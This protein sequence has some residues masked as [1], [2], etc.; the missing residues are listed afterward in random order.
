MKPKQLIIAA[1]S[2]SCA[3]PIFA[4][5]WPAYRG[6]THDGKSTE[7]MPAWPARGPHA[8]WKVPTPNGFSSFSVAD[9]RAFTMILREVDG[10]KMEVLVALNA[11]T[12]KE[13][14]SAHFAPA[15]YEGGGDSGTKENSGGDGPRSTPAIDG[16]HVYVITSDLLIACF[17]S[18]SGK[19]I[20]K[21]DLIRENHGK[22]I[23]W[24]NAASPLIEGNILL[25]AGGGP[26]EAL[27]GLNK[28]NGQVIWKGEDDKITHASPI[29]T[30]IL[31]TRQAIF[32]TQ[33][34]LVAVQPQDGK[35]LWRHPFRFSVSTAA[36]PVV[37]ENIVYCSAGYGVGSSAIELSKDGGTFSAKELWN[38]RGN[39]I[40]NHWSTPVAKDGYLY[41]MFQFKMYGTGPV[42]C[43]DLKTGKQKW[44]Q[45]GFGPG[46]VIL[47]GDDLVALTDDGQVVRIDPQPDAYKEKARFQAISGK[48]W[49]TPAYANGK[50]YVRSTVEGAAFDFSNKLTSR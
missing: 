50:L 14:W 26:G 23:T 1:L 36:S 18:A 22:N 15:K 37:Y 20:W 3:F 11:D 48:C 24:K 44:S 6:P 16:N 7:T 27:L 35:V 8:L 40:A 38:L 13:I 33:K 42:K 21:R 10:V 4:G 43:V 47:V 49:S 45:A 41:G 2:L 32:F 46:Q 12:G 31:G 28:E 5:D 34:G 25:A 9:G 39:D 19:Q 17:D 30:T 29:L